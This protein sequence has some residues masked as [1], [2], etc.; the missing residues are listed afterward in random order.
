MGGTWERG[1]G[2]RER[3]CLSNALAQPYSPLTGKPPYIICGGAAFLYAVRVLRVSGVGIGCS[4]GVLRWLAAERVA[5]GI[6]D[7]A[8]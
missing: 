4:A 2:A 8:F 6:V 7:A 1:I 3:Q 5:A